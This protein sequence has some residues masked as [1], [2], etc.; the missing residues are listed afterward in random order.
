M[1]IW[2]AAIGLRDADVRVVGHTCSLM[3]VQAAA[4]GAGARRPRRA[5]PLALDALSGL[6]H[7]RAVVEPPAPYRLP[8][9]GMDG[10]ARWRHGVVERVAAHGDAMVLLRAAQPA[11]GTVVLG[12]WAP[13]E[14]LA[15]DALVQW[16][17]SLLVDVDHRPFLQLAAGD[18]LLA[19][20]VAGAPW[21]RPPVR[22]R[23]HEALMWAITEQLIEYVEAAK[24]QR[25][26]VWLA[27]R[28]CELTGLYDA[29][30]PQ[31]ILNLAPAQIERLGLSA[32]RTL[33]LR[34]VCRLLVRGIDLDTQDPA[35]RLA[36]QRRLREIPGIGAWTLACLATRGQGDPDA[37][38]SGD[39]GLLKSI[40]ALAAR[41][42]CELVDDPTTG[43]AFTAKRDRRERNPLASEHQ[44]HTLIDRYRP[45][46]TYAAEHLIVG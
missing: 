18:S 39:L 2:R 22:Y 16:R 38:I 23:A 26:L 14:Q 15:R 19:R 30:T 46:R 5:E 29:P 10:V 6:A 20:R 13:D 34:Q 35:Q 43:Q 31:A 40:G 11:G 36:D 25:G 9:N 28:R 42:A 7:A 37:S 27:G 12:A 45:W 3:A 1:P 4:A 24:I 8:R 33:L 17:R 32:R 44:V 21:R 41:G